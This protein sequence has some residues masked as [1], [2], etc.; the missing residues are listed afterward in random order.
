MILTKSSGIGWDTCNEISHY[1]T[2]VRC[3]CGTHLVTKYSG[4]IIHWRGYHW[5]PICAFDKISQEIVD[6]SIYTMGY[7]DEF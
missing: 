7:D 5:I 6:K 1:N 2:D 3:G 4:I